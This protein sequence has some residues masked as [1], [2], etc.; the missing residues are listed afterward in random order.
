VPGNLLFVAVFSD[1]FANC[2][3]LIWQNLQICLILDKNNDFF[4]CV[5][6]FI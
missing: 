4:D 2:L 1:Y 6:S 5:Y 3:K